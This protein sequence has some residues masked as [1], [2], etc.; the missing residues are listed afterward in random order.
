MIEA[1]AE[2]KQSANMQG[3]R[4]FSEKMKL[5]NSIRGLSSKGNMVIAGKSGK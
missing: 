3:L 5:S 2:Y 4:S 1:E